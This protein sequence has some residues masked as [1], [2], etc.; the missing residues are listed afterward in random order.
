[1]K[2]REIVGV[3]KIA[4]SVKKQLEEFRPKVPLLIALRKKGMNERH[5][6]MISETMGFEV[7]FRP[8]EDFTFE[9]ALQMNLMEKV[10]R[11]VEIGETAGKE[12]SIEQM[13]ESMLGIWENVKFMIVGYK[14][15][16]I[17]RGYDEIQVILDEHIV[18]T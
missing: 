10:E 14:N 1:M 13:L 15:T 18:N 16:H 12:Y 11:V 17:I 9:R 4:D 6:N 2:D 5:W 3:M 8:D 7:P